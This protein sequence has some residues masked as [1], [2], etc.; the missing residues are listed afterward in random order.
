MNTSI[1][2]PK[3]PLVIVISGIIGAGKSTLIAL[4]GARLVHEGLR[5]V[6]VPEPVG[7]WEKLGLLERYYGDIS[8]W[9][10]TFQ[11]EAFRSRIMTIRRIYE[12]NRDAD[13]MLMERSPWDDQIFMEML[14]ED[15]R[16][17]DMEW[18]LYQSWCEMWDLLLPVYPSVFVHLDPTVDECQNRVQRRG[19][20]GEDKIT[21]EYQQS[22]KEKHDRFFTSGSLTVLSTSGSISRVDTGSGEVVESMIMLKNMMI[23]CYHLQTKDNFRD[24]EDAKIKVTDI[25]KRII[26]HHRS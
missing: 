18:E 13:V 3:T 16:I 15:H 5:V 19:R 26:E 1:S 22:L 4:L 17:T 20:G 12:E 14:H 7:G 6:V 25:F 10:Y 9:G 24:L 2:R 21:K 11:T 23:P 8:R